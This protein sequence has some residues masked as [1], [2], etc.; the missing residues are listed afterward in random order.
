MVICI[1]KWRVSQFLFVCQ[2]VLFSKSKF[3][4]LFVLFL[5]PSRN[6]HLFSLNCC[7][8]FCS[9]HILFSHQKALV[10]SVFELIL[11]T[12]EVFICKHHFIFTFP[13]PV[14][15]FLVQLSYTPSCSLLSRSKVGNVVYR[16]LNHEPVL[17]RDVPVPSLT[18][19]GL[20]RVRKLVTWELVF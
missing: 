18:F 4:S 17:Q 10:I 12:E 19:T 7:I 13:S 2:K 8:F 1:L 16:K 9:L 6:N 15:P 14:F 11:K 5:H 3:F 20:P